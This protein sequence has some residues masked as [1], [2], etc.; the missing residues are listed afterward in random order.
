MTF[1]SYAQNFEDVLLWRALKGIK[2]GFYIDIGAQDPIVDSVSFAFYRNGWRGV[3]VEP[4][5]QY[6]ALLEKERPDETVERLAI[7]TPEGSM[8]FFQ[9]PDTGLSTADVAIA[10]R[11]RQAGCA[12]V[13]TQVEV[14]GL[15]TLLDRYDY[16]V[17]HWLKV[18]V[19]GFE[20]QVL[21]S[22]KSS[23]V[24]PWILLIESTAPGTQTQTHAAWEAMVLEKG[25][26]Y[27]YF[28]GLNRY[29]VH[30]SRSGLLDH[31]QVPVSIF[32]EFF[33]S[34]TASQPYYGL[35]KGQLQEVAHEKERLQQLSEQQEAELLAARTRIETLATEVPVLD[36]RAAAVEAAKVDLEYVI[37]QMTSELAQSKDETALLNERLNES[38]GN[39]HHWWRRAVDA[40]ARVTAIHA[41]SSWQLTRPWR[42]AGR[43]GHRLSRRLLRGSPADGSAAKA[44]I[45]KSLAYALSWLYRHPRLLKTLSATLRK[46][47][48][49]HGVMRKLHRRFVASPTSPAQSQHLYDNE[50]P[51]L[52]RDELTSGARHIL[53]LLD[54]RQG[55]NTKDI[56]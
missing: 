55:S 53:A 46:T 9:I 19:E 36:A 52:D 23:P 26:H 44:A 17:V 48:F 12:V 30:E 25:Y 27:A 31:F 42:F 1:V 43:L 54:A 8:T 6:A 50:T 15:D 4:T 24:R 22:W 40:E 49:L 13:E 20:K 47:P 39:A 5:P 2:H 33:L 32:D 34:G 29:Y 3:H 7:G 14:L 16:K 10:D 35:L 11:H 45:R 21:E 51:P 18:D 41:S 37:A 38:L 28:D 56:G